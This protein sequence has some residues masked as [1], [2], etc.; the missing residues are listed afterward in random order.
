M[1]QVI[2]AYLRC[3]VNHKQNDWVSLLPMAQFAYNSSTTETTKLSPFF[4]NYGY[5]LSAYREAQPTGSENQLARVQT[6]EIRN[7][8]KNLAD[9]LQFVAEKNAYYY[10]QGR[11]Q[12]PTLREGDKVYLIRRNI[13]TK[14]P[15]DKLDHKKLGP[16]RIK[17]T[18]GRLNYQLD[19][20]RTMNI[21]PVFHISLLEKAPLGA[22]PAPITEIEP[23]N[24]NAEYE[25]EEILDHRKH[26]RSI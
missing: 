10:N 24:P 25:V 1:N 5:E 4:A 17:K 3:Y 26:Y 8:H 22:P 6:E 9:D 7:L 11:S 14:R 12:E 21:H 13:K 20:P 16:F 18:M 19:L 23:I 15:S 2:E